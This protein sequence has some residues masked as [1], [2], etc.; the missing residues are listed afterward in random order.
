MI[1]YAKMDT[2]DAACPIR[3]LRGFL[4]EGTPAAPGASHGGG[5]RYSLEHIP[6][7]FSCLSLL[8]AFSFFPP[9][10]KL[11]KGRGRMADCHA[12]PSLFLNTYTSTA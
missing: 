3:L 7:L 10:Y 4:F 5:F 9:D 8:Y 2:V 11:Q 1:F 6:V 12:A